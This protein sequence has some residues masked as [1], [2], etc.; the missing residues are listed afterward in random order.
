MYQTQNCDHE[1]FL[2]YSLKIILLAV[3]GIKPSAI[4]M[5]SIHYFKEPYPQT[6]DNVCNGYAI[7]KCLYHFSLLFVIIIKVILSITSESIHILWLL[8]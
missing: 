2:K 7:S 4:C 5:L 8:L 3:L 1:Y 6:K